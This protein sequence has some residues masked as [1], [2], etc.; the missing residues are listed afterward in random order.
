[1]AL[2]VD[3]KSGFFSLNGEHI[4]ELNLEQSDE[5]G[6]IVLVTG[7][8]ENTEANGASLQFKGLQIWSLDPIPPTPTPAPTSSTPQQPISGSGSTFP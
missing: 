1:M 2:Y 8:G 5:K 4:E 7:M 3:E 6:D